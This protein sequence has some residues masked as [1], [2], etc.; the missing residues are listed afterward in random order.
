MSSQEILFS[1][2]CATPQVIPLFLLPT[3]LTK[4]TKHL[5]MASMILP[6][7]LSFFITNA[8]IKG[9]IIIMISLIALIIGIKYRSKAIGIYGFAILFLIAS[10][11]LYLE[12]AFPA[13]A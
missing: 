9:L 8:S 3:Q 5:F 13:D 11:L 6:I 1:F 12:Y 2:I 7:I 4:E 10:L